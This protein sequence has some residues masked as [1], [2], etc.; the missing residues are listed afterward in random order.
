MGIGFGIFLVAVGAI[1]KYAVKDNLTGID[2]GVVGVILMIAGVAAVLLDLLWLI[3]R[4]RRVSTVGERYVDPTAAR[5]VERTTRDD[6][7]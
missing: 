5:T 7:V 3:P 4:R 2:L 6:T 1:L